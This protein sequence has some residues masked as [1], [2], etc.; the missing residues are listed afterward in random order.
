MKIYLFNTLSFVCPAKQDS[1]FFQPAPGG[2][3]GAG[4]AE[5][6]ACPCL[7]YFLRFR[8]LLWWIKFGKMIEKV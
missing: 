3:F 8:F 6:P 2:L 7:S 5:S 4:G 1:R